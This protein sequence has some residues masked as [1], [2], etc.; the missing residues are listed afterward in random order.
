MRAE[1][2]QMIEEKSRFVRGIE[3]LLRMDK[4]SM[5]DSLIYRLDMQDEAGEVY[6]EYVGIAWETGGAQ[7]LLVTGYSNGAILKAIIKEVY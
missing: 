5:L 4:N 2:V 1:T 3:M 7:K 6:D